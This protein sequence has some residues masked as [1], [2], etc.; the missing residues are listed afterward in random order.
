MRV[1]CLQCHA[2]V[3]LPPGADP[4]ATTWCGCCTQKHHHGRAAEA[5]P[6]NGGTGHPGERCPHPDPSGCTA[7]TPVGEDCPGGHCGVGVTG[8]T[9]CRP[10]AR[11]LVPG[12]TAP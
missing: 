3:D 7:L 2:V 5:C 12:E 11:Y 8:C 4:H 6:G 9:V 1:A 10:V